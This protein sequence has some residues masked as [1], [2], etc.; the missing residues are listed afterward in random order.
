MIGIEWITCKPTV[1]DSHKYDASERHHIR[2]YSIGA[3][4]FLYSQENFEIGDECR[5]EFF[6][7]NV[8]HLITLFDKLLQML[9]NHSVFPIATLAFHLPNKIGIV[10]VVLTEYCKKGLVVHPHTKIGIT[11]FLCCDIAILITYI[12][13]SLID[14]D[15]NLVQ[16]SVGLLRNDASSTHATKFHAPHFLIHVQLTAEL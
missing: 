9:V 10:F 14:A 11:H 1:V 3:V 12:L 13:I 7:R 15:K 5:G 2:P 8:F 16:L 6:K 4:T